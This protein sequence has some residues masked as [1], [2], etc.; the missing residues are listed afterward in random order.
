[1]SP[2]LKEISGNT[3]AISVQMLPFRVSWS[4]KGLQGAAQLPEGA[5]SSE[6][7]SLTA[8]V[9]LVPRAQ[10][11]AA[12]AAPGL[13]THLLFNNGSK[14]WVFRS[15]RSLCIYTH[16]KSQSRGCSPVFPTPSTLRSQLWDLLPVLCHSN[17]LILICYVRQCLPF[18]YQTLFT[19]CSYKWTP[20]T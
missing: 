9:T 18:S 20:L 19:F 2:V 5:G 17:T 13:S 8:A 1:M 15:N 11:V 3:L 7:T 12:E 10:D 14:C 6:Q 4:R 16:M